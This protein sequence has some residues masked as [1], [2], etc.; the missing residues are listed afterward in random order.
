MVCL[1]NN[2]LT[3]TPPL[4]LERK[5]GSATLTVTNTCADAPGL[6]PS[7]GGITAVFDYFRFVRGGR[8][9]LGRRAR[10][11]RWCGLRGRRGAVRNW[12]PESRDRA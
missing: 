3:F 4:T 11:G 9:L 10:S 7:H 1:E 6:T 5:S 2:T 12:R 8:A